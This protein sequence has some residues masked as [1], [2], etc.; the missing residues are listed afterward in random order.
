MSTTESPYPRSVTPGIENQEGHSGLPDPGVYVGLDWIR[1]TGPGS[2]LPAVESF[3][4][5]RFGGKAMANRGAKWFKNGYSWDPGVMLSWGHKAEIIQVDIQGQRLRLLDGAARIDLLRAL[6]APESYRTTRTGGSSP[7]SPRSLKSST[8]LFSEQDTAPT[9]PLW[10]SPFGSVLF[11][12][13][14]H[15]GKPPTS[16]QQA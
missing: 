2:L 5:D 7:P 1:C 12:T 13:H 6:M 9:P 14:L 8:F 15:C 4:H 10:H 16:A 11:D 3:L